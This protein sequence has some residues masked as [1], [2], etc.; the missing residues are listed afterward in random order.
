MEVF[1]Q[2]EPAGKN[3]RLFYLY[4]IC[5]QNII[6]ALL[7]EIE[8]DKYDRA[9]DK[10][11]EEERER[12]SERKEKGNRRWGELIGRVGDDKESQIKPLGCRRVPERSDQS[13]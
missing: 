11:E 3:I 5:F 2:G 9:T 7:Q 6:P 4:T 10:W 13:R 8:K 12:C 1:P